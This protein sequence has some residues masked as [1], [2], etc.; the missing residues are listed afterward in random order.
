M[1]FEKKWGK[2]FLNNLTTK[3][4][5]AGRHLQQDTGALG[6]VVRR[7]VVVCVLRPKAKS[8]IG[9]RGNVNIV[10]REVSS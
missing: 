10:T 7:S 3:I 2:L 6:T 1:R 9:N 8:C 5:P 4:R